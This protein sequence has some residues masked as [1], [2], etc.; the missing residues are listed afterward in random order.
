MNSYLKAYNDNL[1]IIFLTVAITD[2]SIKNQVQ[3]D[4]ENQW[5]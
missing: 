1:L 4:C 3:R 2:L 5:R